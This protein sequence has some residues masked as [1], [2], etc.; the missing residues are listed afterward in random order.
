[1]C[2]IP[3]RGL[4]QNEGD[5]WEGSCAHGICGNGGARNAGRT[6]E[7]GWP[8]GVWQFKSATSAEGADCG[9][10]EQRC[11]N[12]RACRRCSAGRSHAV[13][14]PTTA[15]AE[16]LLCLRAKPLLFLSVTGFLASSHLQVM[17]SFLPPP[18][19]FCCL[20]KASLP[21]RFSLGRLFLR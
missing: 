18:C 2:G 14:L 19:L 3:S 1:M 21:L 9:R 15:P 17:L 11:R 13:A 16:P 10:R 7:A 4:F 12:V 20:S 6:E 5:D 8:G